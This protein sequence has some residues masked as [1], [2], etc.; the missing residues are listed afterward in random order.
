MSLDHQITDGEHQPIAVEHDARAFAL[1]TE[2]V[3]GARVGVDVG[4]DADDGG[5]EIVNR[6]ILGRC[7]RDEKGEQTRRR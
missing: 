7:G 4:L 1:V 2:V 6:T 3:A 5:N